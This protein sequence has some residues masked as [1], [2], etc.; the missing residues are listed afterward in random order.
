VYYKKKE[1]AIQQRIQEEL[2]LAEER[3]RERERHHIGQ[4]L[5]DELLE[6]RNI[7]NVMIGQIRTMIFDLYPHVLEDRGLV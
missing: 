1:H 4:V 5:H 3:E 2:I 6:I 7:V